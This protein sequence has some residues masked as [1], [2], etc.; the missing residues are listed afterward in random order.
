MWETRRTK[1]FLKFHLE[2]EENNIVMIIIVNKVQTNLDGRLLECNLQLTTT[3]TTTTTTI[4]RTTTTTL[5][6]KY[7]K[8]TAS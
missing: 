1:H 2:L 6:F 7:V 4:T 3:T 5:P 8:N